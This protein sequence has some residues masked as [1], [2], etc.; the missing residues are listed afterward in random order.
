MT[1]FCCKWGMVM[2]DDGRAHLV[3]CDDEGHLLD[4]H[5][6]CETCRCHPEIDL[7]SGIVT[8]SVVQ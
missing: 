7:E 2:S 5:S 6:A 3:P 1:E 8:H 4:P